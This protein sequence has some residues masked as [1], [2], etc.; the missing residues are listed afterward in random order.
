MEKFEDKTGIVTWEMIPEVGR[1]IME[2]LQCLKA[3]VAYVAKRKFDVFRSLSFSF[4]IADPDDEV[5]D[6]AI[7]EVV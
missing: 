7:A 6:D 5:D 4:Q 3:A 1:T 2:K